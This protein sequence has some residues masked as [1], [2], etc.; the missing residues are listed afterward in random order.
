MQKNYVVFGLLS[1]ALI[2]LFIFSNDEVRSVAVATEPAAKLSTT[3]SFLVAEDDCSVGGIDNIL[4]GNL[5]PG[6]CCT[7]NNQCWSGE[8]GCPLGGGKKDR[9]CHLDDNSQCNSN[10]ECQSDNC[11][12][13][14]CVNNP[15]T[16]KDNRPNGAACS[17]NR[18]CLSN[19]CAISTNGY[20]CA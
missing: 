14:R 7:A 10:G 13:G 12:N 4:A 19:R 17:V 8:C 18:D 1:L 2:G 9:C 3:F 20:R 16:G 11:V 5:H 15:I 6:S